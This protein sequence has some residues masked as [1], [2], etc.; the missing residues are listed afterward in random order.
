MSVP[1]SS[2]SRANTPG[3]SKTSRHRTDTEEQRSWV[4]RLLRKYLAKYVRDYISKKENNIPSP[5][6]SY[7]DLRDEN[8]NGK[9]SSR[10]SPSSSAARVGGSK[11]GSS[12]KRGSLTNSSRKSLSE[13]K[14]VEP[15]A[16]SSTYASTERNLTKLLKIADLEIV[17]EIALGDDRISYLSRILSLGVTY[18]VWM[19]V[20]SGWNICKLN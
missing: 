18:V 5:V 9:N 10:T 8:G 1:S 11:L 19:P 7:I 4:H 14:P 12:S 13:S 3:P 6:C 17:E 16:S 20:K 15:S 2:S